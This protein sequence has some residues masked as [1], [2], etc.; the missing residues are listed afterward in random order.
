MSLNSVSTLDTHI[1]FKNTVDEMIFNSDNTVRF[2][3]SVAL[4]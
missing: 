1:T 3:D 4:K 2:L